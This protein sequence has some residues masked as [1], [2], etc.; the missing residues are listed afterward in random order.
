[1]LGGVNNGIHAVVGLGGW[2]E[3]PSGASWKRSDGTY[4]LITWRSVN[5][6]LESVLCNQAAG[7]CS[8]HT[9]FSTV[10]R[11]VVKENQRKPVNNLFGGSRHVWLFV[12]RNDCWPGCIKWLCQ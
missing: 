12:Y 1:M 5:T 2:V 9:N 8:L 11:S 6:V 4:I 10:L 3:M 7:G